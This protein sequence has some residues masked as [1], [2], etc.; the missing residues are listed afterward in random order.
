MKIA[1]SSSGQEL[2][3]PVDP[4][5]GRCTHFVI[6]DSE[7]DDYEAVENAASEA[8]SGAGIAAA[9]ALAK[10][11]AEIVLT[12]NLGPNAARTLSTLGIKAYRAEGDTVGESVTAFLDG[13][14]VEITSPTVTAKSGL[15]PPATIFPSR[16]SGGGTGGGTGIGGGTGSGRGMGMGGGGGRGMGGGRGPGGGRGMGG[17]GRGAGGGRGR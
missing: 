13:Q 14:K 2:D 6:V 8:G 17:G 15:N 12:G 9:T 7:T 10:A 1:V 11:G 4:R 16:P 3:S 5:F